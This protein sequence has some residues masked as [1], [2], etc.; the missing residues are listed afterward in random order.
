MELSQRQKEILIGI[1]LGDGH[2]E[3]NGRNVRL[4]V[5]HGLR[6]K[7]YLYWK[8]NEFKGLCRGK[9]RLVIKKDSRTDKIYSWWHFSTSSNSCFD[10]LYKT[11]YFAKRKI[12][13]KNISDLLRSPLSLAVWYMDDGYKRNDCRALRISTDCFTFKKQISLKECL[14]KNFG[15]KTNIHKKGKTWNIYVPSSESKDFSLIIKEYV[16]REMRYK[17]V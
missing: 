8:Y 13:P 14:K 3:K 10:D 7:E 1:I 2:L 17:I 6:Q 12:I 5:D 11:F 9:P 15:I 16:F 4:R